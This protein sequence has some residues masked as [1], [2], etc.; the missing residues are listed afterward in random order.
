MDR[1]AAARLGRKQTALCV[2]VTSRRSMPLLKSRK[3]P[4]S[5]ERTTRT[6]PSP[7]EPWKLKRLCILH[8]LTVILSALG[9]QPRLLSSASARQP[10][11]SH[12]SSAGATRRG[13]KNRPQKSPLPFGRPPLTT[14]RTPNTP[15]TTRRCSAA[16]S[17]TCSSVARQRSA[18][19]AALREVF[20]VL[21]LVSSRVSAE[22]FLVR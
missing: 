18:R 12:D 3:S 2:C 15:S 17:R 11:G 20:A 10:R 16:A 5:R 6:S 7:E 14:C 4:I 22:S 21:E 1:R 9:P 8:V 19:C 13:Y